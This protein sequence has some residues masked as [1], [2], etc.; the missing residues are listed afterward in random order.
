MSKET[1]EKVFHDFAGLLM[2]PLALLILLGEMDPDFEINGAT[3]DGSDASGAG[4]LAR[5]AGN[6]N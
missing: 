4:N 3:S 6:G 2:M 5:I 1:A